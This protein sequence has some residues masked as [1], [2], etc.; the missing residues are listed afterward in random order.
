MNKPLIDIR[1]ADDTSALLNFRCGVEMMD[2]FI[3]DKEKGLAKFIGLGLSNLW[4][5]YE[6]E[7]VVAFFALSK[8]ALILNSEDIYNITGDEK[9]SNI[10]PSKDEEKFWGQEKYPALEIDYFAVSEEKR[11]EHLGTA[12]VSTI[13]DFAAQDRLSATKFI[14]VEAYDTKK[15][16][17]VDFYKKCGFE[18]SEKGMD[19]NRYKEMYGEQPTTKRMYRVVIPS[20]Y[21]L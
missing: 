8:D 21:S 9:L 19:R 13:V 6:G 4:L 15:Y 2:D 1:R 3:Q 12:L 17:T 5:V 11:K 16:S 7:R 14:T 18:L 10:L 20:T